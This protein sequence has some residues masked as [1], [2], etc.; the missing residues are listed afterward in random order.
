MRP[1]RLWDQLRQTS[2]RP[3]R[4][5]FILLIGGTLL[6]LGLAMIVLPGP[7]MLVI[8][9]GLAILSLEFVWARKLLK[10][11]RASLSGIADHLRR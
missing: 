8:P 9:M 7:A 6:L 10:K 4:R 3:L 1:L 5:F 2:L 11:A